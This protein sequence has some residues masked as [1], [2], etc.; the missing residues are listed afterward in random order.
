[1]V[2]MF[3]S[4][5]KVVVCLH[6]LAKSVLCFVVSEPYFN[7][8]GKYSYQYKFVFTQRKQKKSLKD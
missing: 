3:L 4:D 8:V 7:H 6:S 1:M 2:T 5:I